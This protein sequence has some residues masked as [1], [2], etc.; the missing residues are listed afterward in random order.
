MKLDAMLSNPALAAKY[1]MYG[2]GALDTLKN[3]VM[4]PIESVK[5]IGQMGAAVIITVVV[6][7]LVAGLVGWYI[8]CKGLG[9]VEGL[10]ASG[11][12][13]GA[14]PS[15]DTYGYSLFNIDGTDS[16]DIS[17]DPMGRPIRDTVTNYIAGL[18]T[19][20]FRKRQ[21]Q[22]DSEAFNP[23]AVVRG[24]EGF[25]DGDKLLMDSEGVVLQESMNDPVGDTLGIA[26]PLLPSQGYEGMANGGNI[27]GNILATNRASSLVPSATAAGENDWQTA[28]FERKAKKLFNHNQENMANVGPFLTISNVGASEFS[29]NVDQFVNT[30]RSPRRTT[31]EHYSNKAAPGMVQTLSSKGVNFN[32]P[33]IGDEVGYNPY[34]VPSAPI[35]GNLRMRPQNWLQMQKKKVTNE[36][37]FGLSAYH[38]VGASGPH[39]YST[40]GYGSSGANIVTPMAYTSDQAKFL[41]VYDNN[42][43]A[44]VIEKDCDANG[45]CKIEF[46]GGPDNKG[47]LLNLV[48]ELSKGERKQLQNLIQKYTVY[49]LDAPARISQLEKKKQLSAIDTGLTFSAADQRELSDLKSFMSKKSNAKDI[50]LYN[51]LVQKAAVRLTQKQYLIP[52]YP[53]YNA[54]KVK[55]GLRYYGPSG[56]LKRLTKFVPSN[57]CDYGD[58]ANALG[59]NDPQL[60]PTTQD[61]LA[62]A[63]GSLQN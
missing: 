33:Y 38:S 50:K 41:S 40:G 51:E 49:Q 58:S 48:Y 24:E 62:D 25:V 9:V 13:M 5:K 12:W 37:G 3:I 16:A 18:Q 15:S 53:P 55:P 60:S 57:S 28:V 47:Q 10:S 20:E 21:A 1:G 29:P 43:D 52:D 61:K 36:E 14:P 42:Q 46:V 27:Y 35:T 7:L 2:G 26:P 44:N 11:A 54:C 30:K 8:S 32:N 17:Y 39:G 45:R 4:A 31:Y 6:L 56:N 63:V 34:P 22:G 23:N 59:Y 19:A